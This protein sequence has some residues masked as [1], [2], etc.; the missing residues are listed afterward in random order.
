MLSN[1]SPRA[2]FLALFAVCTGLLAY[3]LYLQHVVGLE[4][5]P[6]CIMQRYA[7]VAVAL[8]ALVAGLHGPARTGSI[9]YGVVVALLAAAGGTVAAR[10]SL[11]QRSPPDIAECGPGLEY[12]IDSFGVAEALPMIF[13]GAG[14][15][16]AIDWT[17]LG[18][19]IANWSL[20]AFVAVGLFGL[21]MIARGGRRP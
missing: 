10:Q 3:G 21:A 9:V 18:L 17:F 4:P 6:M 2:L 13:R 19:T 11:L 5:C 15:C 1:L 20:L 8:V 7:F 12:L 14:D 16:A